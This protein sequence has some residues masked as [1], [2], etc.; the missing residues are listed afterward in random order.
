[1]PAAASTCVPGANFS[2]VGEAG[3]EVA[4]GLDTA[5]V[6]V[7][8]VGAHDVLALAQRVVGDHINFN[9]RPGQ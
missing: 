1:M 2:Q 5:Q 3:L 6:D 8:A 9:A 4:A 7:V